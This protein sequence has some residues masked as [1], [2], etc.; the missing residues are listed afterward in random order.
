MA[1]K[2]PIW[3]Y[4]DKDEAKATCRIYSKTLLLG[5]SL[6]KQQTVINI[7]NHLEKIHKEEW[8]KYI[9]AQSNYLGMIKVRKVENMK[10]P[11]KCQK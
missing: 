6:P 10:T 7:K 3:D 4:F 1:P 2:N 8:Q 5:S 11:R 9:E